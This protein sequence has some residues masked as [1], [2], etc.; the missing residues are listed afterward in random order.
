MK[1]VCDSLKQRI[2]WANS[3][4]VEPLWP[5]GPLPDQYVQGL[6]RKTGSFVEEVKTLDDLQILLD[7]TSWTEVTENLRAHNPAAFQEGSC[8]FQ[9]EIPAGYNAFC[10]IALVE[11]LNDKQINSVRFVKGNHGSEMQLDLKPQVTDT[12]SAIVDNDGL[13]TWYPGEFTKPMNLDELLAKEKLGYEDLV[14]T[15][16][17][18]GRVLIETADKTLLDIT[19]C[20]VKFTR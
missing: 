16:L 14:I 2:S 10:G 8:Y 7:K 6:V 19:G 3:Q 20:A 17:P 12:I 11:N 18:D 15:K 4:P 9:G 13:V 1:K 5:N